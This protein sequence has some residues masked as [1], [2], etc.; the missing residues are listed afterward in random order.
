[1][2]KQLF[3]VH[4]QQNQQQQHEEVKDVITGFGIIIVLCFSQYLIGFFLNYN[5]FTL[6]EYFATCVVSLFAFV[7]GFELYFKVSDYD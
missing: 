4:H 6:Y 5:N 7:G 1:M 3:Q 2:A